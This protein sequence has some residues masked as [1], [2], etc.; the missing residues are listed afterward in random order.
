VDGKSKET[1]HEEIVA[2]MQKRG[3]LHVPESVSTAKRMKE[4]N[5]VPE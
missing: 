3:F 4:E 1:V 5:V 2:I